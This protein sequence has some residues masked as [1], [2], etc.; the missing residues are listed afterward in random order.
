[1]DRSDTEQARAAVRQAAHEHRAS[2]VIDAGDGLLFDLATTPDGRVAATAGAERTVSLWSVPSGRRIGRVGGFGDAVRAVSFSGD[3]K[4]IA[5]AAQDGEI[6]IAPAGGGQRTLLMRLPAGDF[7]RS[8][9]FDADAARLAV[10]TDKGWVA[11]IRISDRTVQELAAR[12]GVPAYTVSF[13]RGG[14]NVVSGNEQ[15]L[16][17]IWSLDGGAQR[18]LTQG[19][20]NPVVDAAFDPSGE[21]LATAD[22]SGAVRRWD[23]SSARKL[24]KLQIADKAITSLRFSRDGRR[25]V[26]ATFDGVVRESAYPSGKL[27][28]ELRGHQGVPHVDYIAGGSGIVSAGEDDGS[29]RVW[30]PPQTRLPRQPG[31]EPRFGPG[32]ELVTSG[33]EGGPVHVWN[34]ATGKEDT[35]T[36]HQ[37]PSFARFAAKGRWIVSASF[38]GSVRLSDAQTGSARAV[39]TLPGP[40]YAVGI[41]PAGKRIAVGGDTKLVVQGSDGKDR[42]ELRGHE[43][44]VNALAFSPSGKHV[45]TAGDDGTAR[46]WDAGDGSRGPILRGHEGPVFAVAYSDDGDFVATAGTDASVR[47][48]PVSG[49]KPVILVGHV[50]PVNSVA[51]DDG[52]DRLVS[53]GDDGTIRVWD[54]SGGDTLV[55]VHRH[56][57]RATGADISQDGR[58]VVSSGDDGMRITTCE[59]CG[60]FEEALRVARARSPHELTAAERQRL[61]SGD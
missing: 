35:Y 3:A 32:D 36:G 41:D 45:V 61:L 20:A 54:T 34:P 12:D 9:D 51:F 5:I 57:G 30:A 42:V 29:V 15:G 58:R 47:I 21:E 25:I 60:T 55:V 48:W 18:T 17:R 53:A 52:G 40:K 4:R 1:M 38:D 14:R 22:S 31:V 7:A 33:D 26:T 37:A 46:V 6:A 27:L 16:A 43:G 44:L 28:S 2:R 49:G 24:T 59:V 11:L 10:A 50:G 39:P 13:D 23:A 56:K 8:V 19:M